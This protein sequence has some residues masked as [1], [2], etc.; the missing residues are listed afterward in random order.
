[1]LIA[2]EALPYGSIYETRANLDRGL[3]FDHENIQYLTAN[4]AEGHR[5]FWIALIQAMNSIGAP[6]DTVWGYELVAEQFYRE[7]SPPLNLG[8][9]WSRPGTARPTTWPCPGRSS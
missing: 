4:G 3:T 7:T 8:S 6:L 9:E 2:A 5:L 1:M